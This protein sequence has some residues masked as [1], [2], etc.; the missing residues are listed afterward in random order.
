MD[1]ANYWNQFKQYGLVHQKIKRSDP[2]GQNDPKK[3][4]VSKKPNWKSKHWQSFSS[5][6]SGSSGPSKLS[7]PSGPIRYSGTSG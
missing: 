7:E 6:L 5:G 2:S 1:Q 3:Q 4:K